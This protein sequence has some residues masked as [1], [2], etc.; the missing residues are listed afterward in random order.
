MFLW[1]LTLFS[2][3]NKCTADTAISQSWSTSI[4]HKTF[5]ATLLHL[6]F[7]LLEPLTDELCENRKHAFSHLFP[8]TRNFSGFKKKKKTQRTLLVQKHLVGCTILQ[9]VSW[10]QG[11]QAS[12]ILGYLE[13]PYHSLLSG[14][15][16]GNPDPSAG[17]QSLCL[18]I[19]A[20]LIRFPFTKDNCTTQINASAALIPIL[21]S[22][23]GKM[24]THLKTSIPTQVTTP[25]PFP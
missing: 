23:G 1:S 22:G 18:S 3:L 9:Q 11:S 4:T 17:K 20:L 6:N 16:H 10:W 25:L 24:R 19:P 2:G 13:D 5:T 7:V 12:R 15:P 14:I 21:T 8:K